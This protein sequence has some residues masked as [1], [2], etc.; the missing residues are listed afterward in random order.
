MKLVTTLVRRLFG[1]Y[2]WMMSICSAS[3]D[4]PQHTESCAMVSAVGAVC[5]SI[6][7]SNVGHSS[8]LIFAITVFVLHWQMELFRSIIIL[9]SL[10]ERLHKKQFSEW[11][12]IY[13]LFGDFSPE[14]KWTMLDCKMNCKESV[15]LRS[16]SLGLYAR[17]G[18]IS[19]G[20][21]VI[22]LILFLWGCTR[23]VQG[24]F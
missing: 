16:H 18:I 11:L 20:F 19:F 1:L 22:V 3:W 6:V 17:L 9:I 10:S 21:L 5:S 13:N 8:F 15:V 24:F 4:Q 2:V 23:S 7:L 14:W 12:V